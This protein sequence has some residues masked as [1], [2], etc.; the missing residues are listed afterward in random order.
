VDAR[1]VR[2]IVLMRPALV[3]SVADCKN[4]QNLP[5]DSTDS[6][7]NPIIKIESF[8]I[9]VYVPDFCLGL[10]EVRGDPDLPFLDAL[11][12]FAMNF[13]HAHF[14][15]GISTSCACS[16]A[17]RNFFL[18]ELGRHDSNIRIN[19]CAAFVS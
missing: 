3:N 19:G 16:A 7:D 13:C 17:G 9:L 14:L 1:N 15:D 2:N 5:A 6:N 4:H 8:S 12:L 18:P 10:Q 11:S